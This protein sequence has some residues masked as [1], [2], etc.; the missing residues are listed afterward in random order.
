MKIHLY[1]DLADNFGT[2]HE[3]DVSTP[4]EALRAMTMS[5]KSWRSYVSDKQCKIHTGK[6]ELGEEEL[7]LT[8]CEEIH[9]IPIIEGAGGDTGRNLGKIVGGVALIGL[10]GG[11]AGIFGGGLISTIVSSTLTSA[12]YSMVY[13]GASALLTNPQES[14]IVDTLETAENKPSYIFNGA[15]NSVEQGGA[16]PLVYGFVRTGS[17]VISAGLVTED[18]E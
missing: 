13:A 3:Y 1:G 4:K 12:A 6:L 11:I 9:V 15:T 17:I 2:L 5:H 14:P 10:T 8:G 16:I 7:T 18:R